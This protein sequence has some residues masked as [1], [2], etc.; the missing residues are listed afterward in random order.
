MDRKSGQKTV[1]VSDKGDCYLKS[2]VITWLIYMAGV[3]Y[4][5][6][7]EGW[8]NVTVYLKSFWGG[9]AC[10]YQL[11]QICKRYGNVKHLVYVFHT[12]GRQRGEPRGY[13]F[14]EYA[15]RQVQLSHCCVDG[16]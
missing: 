3:L 5:T 4:K 6:L 11:M 16:S 10:R 15:S 7:I 1:R 8:G 12:H 14:V 13:C 2:L 9:C